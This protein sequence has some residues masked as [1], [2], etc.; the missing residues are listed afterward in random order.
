MMVYGVSAFVINCVILL[1]DVKFYCLSFAYH[2]RWRVGMAVA[3]ALGGGGGWGNRPF[4]L[5]TVW[6]GRRSICLVNGIPR[7]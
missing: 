3:G 5:I 4:I 2:H 7:R 1:L 6:K